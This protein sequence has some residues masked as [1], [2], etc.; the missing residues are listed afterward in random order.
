MGYFVLFQLE[1][2][3]NK[4]EMRSNINLGIAD[5]R[6]SI[7]TTTNAYAGASTSSTQTIVYKDVTKK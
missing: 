1:Q 2:Y 6:I 5:D 3:N 7:C 4:I